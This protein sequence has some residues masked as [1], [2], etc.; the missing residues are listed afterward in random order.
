VSILDRGVRIRSPK[1]VRRTLRKLDREIREFRGGRFRK[2]RTRRDEAAFP[3]PSSSR[4]EPP[5]RWYG[6]FPSDAFFALRR[7]SV[8]LGEFRKIP[9]SPPKKCPD[10]E[11]AK[12]RKCRARRAAPG[13]AGPEAI[14]AAGRAPEPKNRSRKTGSG[15]GVY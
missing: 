14:G 7:G 5:K 4:R 2:S 6:V 9:D 1:S 12:D 8:L 15:T 3:A 11:N 13:A 10:G